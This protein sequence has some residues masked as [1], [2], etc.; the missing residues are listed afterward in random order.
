MDITDIT[1]DV[2]DKTADV[3]DI[4][5]DIPAVRISVFKFIDTLVV[6]LQ[7]TVLV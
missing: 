5:R 3:T 4:S 2:T 7:L 6:N 1:A